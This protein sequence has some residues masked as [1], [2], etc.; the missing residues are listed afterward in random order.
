MKIVKIALLALFFCL[1]SVSGYSMPIAHASTNSATILLD[2]YPLTFPTPPVIINGYTMVPFRAISE[3]M[4]VSV[5]WVPETETILAHKTTANGEINVQLQLGNPSITVNGQISSLPVAPVEK[6]G[7]TLI[8]LS[9]F[10]KQFGASVSWN[11]QTRTVS[12][13]S[14]REHLYTTAFY[15]ISSFGQKQLI[16]SFDSVAFGWSRIDGNGNVT[17]AG[18]DFYWPQAAGDITPE[19]IIDDSKASGTSPYLMVFA[20]DAKGELTKL[21]DNQQLRD[22]AVDQILSIARDKHFEGIVLDFEG[23]GLQGDPSNSKAKYNQ[24]VSQLAKKAHEQNT[25]LTLVLHPLNG[26]YQGYDYAILKTLA[27]DLIIMAYG[28]ESEKSPEPLN[29]VNEAIQLALKQVP[30]D[31]LILGISMGSENE[32]SIN[33]KIGLAKRYGLKGIALWRLGLINQAT[34]AQMNQTI[35]LK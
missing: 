32:Q 11:A 34:M 26:A 2:G 13:T 21:L 18:K 4:G 35:E 17:L 22:K 5:Q 19:S 7:H 6:N 14:P 16:H 3:A 20:G 30:K 31:Q 9:F 8:P 10:S 29:K 15:A 33:A 25:K 23:L 27:D 24:F 28:Y 1:S 12:I